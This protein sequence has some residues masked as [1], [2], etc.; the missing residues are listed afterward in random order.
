MDIYSRQNV[1]KIVIVTH[2]CLS[3]FFSHT[4]E[5]PMAGPAHTLID[6]D[7]AVLASN[8]GYALRQP[9][10]LPVSLTSMTEPSSTAVKG[11]GEPLLNLFKRL[12]SAASRSTHFSSH[13]AHLGIAEPTASRKYIGAILFYLRL[14]NRLHNQPRR[15]LKRKSQ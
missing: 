12:K 5:F 14:L 15:I 1:D 2:H 3:Y 13:G 11:K 8:Y 9:S 10:S 7:E 6:R 4:A